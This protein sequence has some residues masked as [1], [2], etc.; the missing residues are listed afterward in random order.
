MIK[1]L[2]LLALI[3]ASG[4]FISTSFA[5]DIPQ[6][7]IDACAN[8]WDDEWCR[9]NVLCHEAPQNPRCSPMRDGP[10]S[11]LP[12]SAEDIKAIF[13]KQNPEFCPFVDPFPIELPELDP[14]LADGCPFPFPYAYYNAILQNAQFTVL[15]DKITVMQND[16]DTLKID[17][18]PLPEDKL[19]IAIGLGVIASIGA[20]TAAGLAFR[21][22]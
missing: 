22:K 15:D 5:D 7:V 19:N 1:L 11:G 20:V 21:R 16:I 6:A 8:Q 14:C 9:E 2:F 4:T 13:C 17:T 18:V 3:F 10:S 12:T